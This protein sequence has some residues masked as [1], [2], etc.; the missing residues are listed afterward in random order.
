M[1][2]HDLLTF[3]NTTESTNRE[4]FNE[5]E[6]IREQHQLQTSKLILQANESSD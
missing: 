5:I 6:I 1:R 3:W 2:K 4:R